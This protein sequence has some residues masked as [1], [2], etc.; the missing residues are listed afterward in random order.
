MFQI[1]NYYKQANKEEEIFDTYMSIIII[2]VTINIPEK[3]KI[4]YPSASL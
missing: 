1:N 3:D 2:Q 4:I